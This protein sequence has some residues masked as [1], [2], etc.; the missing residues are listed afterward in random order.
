MNTPQERVKFIVIARNNKEARDFVKVM[1][2]EYL[3]Q[4][5]VIVD[6]ED[7]S[8]FGNTVS[9][10]AYLIGRY[11]ENPVIDEILAHLNVRQHRQI[12]VPDWR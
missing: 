10:N 1:C 6:P 7:V 3:G 8:R 9:L 4:P 2:L 5:V 11:F 12:R